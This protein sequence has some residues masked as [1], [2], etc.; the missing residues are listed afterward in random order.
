MLSFFHPSFTLFPKPCCCQKQQVAKILQIRHFVCPPPKKPRITS[1]SG[2]EIFSMVQR[3][4]CCRDD[5]RFVVVSLERRRRARRRKRLWRL[6]EADGR[7]L[8]T[9]HRRVLF[10][11]VHERRIRLSRR[12]FVR[13]VA[14]LQHS[15]VASYVFDT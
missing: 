11:V 14:F 5:R 7:R 13:R 8:A 12:H 1:S 3:R 15:G 10:D 6:V 9:H 4:G 2:D